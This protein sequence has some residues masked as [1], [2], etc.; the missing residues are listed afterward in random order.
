[1]AD[2]RPWGRRV[3]RVFSMS[4]QELVDRLRQFVSGRAD[5]LRYRGHD[6]TSARAYG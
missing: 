1:M 4:R 3:A 5:L 6:N 2:A